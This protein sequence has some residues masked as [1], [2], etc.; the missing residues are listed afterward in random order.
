MRTR[1]GLLI[2]AILMV[3]ATASAVEMPPINTTTNGQR[4]KMLE[5]RVST[6]E[7]EIRA[8]EV[9]GDQI[10][11]NRSDI[12]VNYNKQNNKNKDFDKKIIAHD[13]AVYETVVTRSGEKSTVVKADTNREMIENLQGY[14]VAKTEETG[15]KIENNSDDIKENGTKIE[16]NTTKITNNSTNIENNSHAIANNSGRIDRVESKVNSLENEMNRG[17]AMSAATAS[18]VYPD[19]KPGRVGIGAGM[20]GY[21]NSQAVAVGVAVQP[22][23]N[24]RVNANVATSDGSE[25]MYGAGFGYSFDVFGG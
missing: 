19:M 17:L 25:T 8:I 24:F 5:R 21:G 11:Q 6:T 23:E 22:A 13:G 20:G 9:D 3:G 4:I 14:A 12:L 18:I 15:A 10:E 16:N 7:G 2:G 1:R